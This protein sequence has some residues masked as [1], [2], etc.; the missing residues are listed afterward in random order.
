MRVYYDAT[1][2][3]GVV[4]HSHY[5]NYMERARTEWLRQFGFEQHRL[6]RELGMLFAV[7]WMEIQFLAPARLDDELTVSVTLQAHKQASLSL[8]QTIDRQADHRQLIR[9][10][11]RIAALN[12]QFKPTRLPRELLQ[13]LQHGA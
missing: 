11:V 8:Q 9:A 5:L 1:D 13:L 2:A 4:Y 7:T 3:G 12:S 10:N 6:Y